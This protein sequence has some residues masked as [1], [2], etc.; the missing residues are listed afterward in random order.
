M[1]ARV[2]IP[3]AVG[4]AFIAEF[5]FPSCQAATRVVIS[6][7]AVAVSVDA[8]V[9]SPFAIRNS[10]VAPPVHVKRPP[11]GAVLVGIRRKDRAALILRAL[12][13]QTLLL[14]CVL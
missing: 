1:D 2:W 3:E 12:H 5:S 4:H 7:G 13:I 10:I 9:R 6:V 11:N 8:G 14:S